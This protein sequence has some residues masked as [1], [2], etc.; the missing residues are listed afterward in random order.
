MTIDRAEPLVS[1][2]LSFRNEEKTLPELVRRLHEVL[3][4]L[5]LRY[6]LI[7]VND[8]SG[9][10][11]LGVLAGE[12]TADP[13]V[14]VVNMSRR[15]GV[16]ECMVAGLAYATG[17]A[18]ITMDSDLQDPPEVIPALVEKWHDGADVVYTVRLSR[19]GE[20]FAKTWLA[21]LAYRAI[22]LVSDI[23]VPVDA[24]DYKLIS[25]RVVECVLQMDERSPYLRGLVAWVG[26]R[27]VP[28]Y[29]HRQ[30][31]FA[32]ASR[33]SILFSRGPAK[34]F[35]A[36][37]TF[38]SILPMAA[39]LFLGPL[40]IAIGVLEGLALAVLSV[41]G[42][43]FA[44]WLWLLG[45]MLVLSGLHFL[46]IGAMGLYVGRVLDQVRHRPQYIVE[47]TIGLPKR[48]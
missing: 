15:F 36:G 1:V 12:A 4:P 43:P 23:D 45:L 29:Y 35:F 14:K 39:F 24:G 27:Q 22:R 20:S 30:R 16:Y 33:R 28:V 25:R 40:A 37:I 11:S 13:R 7:F 26:F 38:S 31:R 2:V 47:S 42:V 5:P 8:D 6:E 17:D 18:V 34:V 9:D 21:R 44:G 41:V 19:A 46:G 3:R 48:S 10:R 32:G